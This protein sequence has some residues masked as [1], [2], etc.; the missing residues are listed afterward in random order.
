MF[1]QDNPAYDGLR[2][3]LGLRASA[4][5]PPPPR[6]VLAVSPPGGQVR[7]NIAIRII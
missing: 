2:T 4:A 6:G 7:R 3:S 1:I 5:A